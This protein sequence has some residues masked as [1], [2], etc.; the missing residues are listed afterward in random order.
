MGKL[1]VITDTGT[2][3]FERNDEFRLEKPVI[4]SL[5]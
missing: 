3:N 2:V 4:L 1:S 5:Q